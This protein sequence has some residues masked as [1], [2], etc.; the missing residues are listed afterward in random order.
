MSAE[1]HLAQYQ[2]TVDQAR[3][4]IIA[5]LQTPEV[6]YNAALSINLTAEMLAEIVGSVSS[7]DVVNFFNFVGLNGDALVSSG[8]SVPGKIDDGVVIDDNDDKITISVTDYSGISNSSAAIL[9]ELSNFRA[10]SRFSD[11]DGAGYTVVV[12]DTAFDLDHSFFGADADSNGV[13]D[14]IL[15][16]EDFTNEGD[17]ANTADQSQNHG[18]H[19]A[20]TI[21]SSDASNPGVAP[22]VNV[23][24]LQALGHGGGS[25]S[26]I[27]KA[28][29]WVIDNAREYNVVAVNMSLGDSSN[30]TTTETSWANDEMARLAQLGV[31]TV[32][33]SGNDYENFKTSG[34]GYPAADPNAVSVGAIVS[35]GGASDTF[36]SFSQ[37]SVTLTDIIAPGVAITAGNVGGGT[38]SMSGTSMAAP[39]I[40]GVVALAQQLANDTIGRSL[41]VNEY[42]S[43][44][45][46][47]AVVV[48]DSE[49]AWDGVP[50]T[51]DSFYRVDVHAL[52]ELI[53][54]MGGSSDVPVTPIAS[55]D[56]TSDT[57]TNA[58]IAVGG[59]ETG[60]L[61]QLGDSDWFSIV[62]NAGS[63]Y[64]FTLNGISL[65]DPYLRLYNNSGSYLVSNDDAP[66]TLNSAL[67]FTAATAGTY[68]LSAGSFQGSGSGDYTLSATL[69]S[70]PE[71]EPSTDGGAAGQYT[72]SIDYSGDNDRYLVALEAG[73][74][75]TINLAGESSNS[76]T[77]SDPLVQ[78]LDE[79]F[80]LIRSNDDGGIGLDSE[81]EYTAVHSGNYYVVANDYDSSV[82]SYI[83]DITANSN[84]DTVP[85]NISS[86]FQITEGQ[87]LAGNI[88]FENDADWYAITLSE[89][90]QYAISLTGSS[91]NGSALSDPLL[92]LYDFQGDF[93]IADDDGGSGLNSDMLYLPTSSGTYYIAA[94][95]YDSE[96]GNYLL[97]VQSSGTDVGS[98]TSTAFTV[99]LGSPVTGVIDFA[100]DADWYAITLA[101]GTIYSIDL[102]GSDT[103]SGTLNDPLLGLYDSSGSFLASDDDGGTG[104]NSSLS[105]TPTTSGA[106]YISAH[107]YASGA[108]SYLL[109]VNGA[110]ASSLQL[111]TQISHNLENSTDT[112][113]VEL[114]AGSNYQLNVL[115]EQSGVGTLLDPYVSVENSN[116]TFYRYDDD[117][118]SGLESHLVFSVTESG[119]H[120]VTVGSHSSGSSYVLGFDYV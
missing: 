78:L 102:A 35:S 6:I 46:Q 15:Y 63:S 26:G 9:T 59:S 68:Y 119:T 48:Q 69:V 27:Q 31:V 83:L 97:Q 55:N 81:L 117:S 17:G 92:E 96:T 91:A 87:Q 54:Q 11:I 24:T 71:D 100:N 38:A 49:I 99:N 52:G 95:G 53:L 74:T 110:A 23:I 14:R 109:S 28:L 25:A 37:R 79:N 118:G 34:V 5:N 4:F 47:S 3:T 7:A 112:F 80:T 16:H 64:S 19:V 58:V 51:G 18:T 57:S 107:S 72:G 89:G 44:M 73:T 111:G 43:L 94:N 90:I 84:V 70:I 62:L 40:S 76:G 45:Q 42:L 113:Q 61:E 21:A 93:V 106:Y 1:T 77:L 103:S 50:N 22:G 13:A 67:D 88:D 104:Y 86:S 65:E 41:T 116:S 101:A 114:V 29:Q 85:D 10:D 20:S 30:H 115:G 8:S 2:V 12:I 39:F 108:G 82:G 33:A 98:D 75:Y 66:N 120:I 32:V 36:A 105:Y 56:I 60:T